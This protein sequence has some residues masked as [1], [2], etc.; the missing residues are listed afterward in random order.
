MANEKV[1][2]VIVG[3]SSVA[4]L[5]DNLKALRKPGF[6]RQELERIETICRLPDGGK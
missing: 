1:T 3:A 6:T 2:S 4:Q 5:E